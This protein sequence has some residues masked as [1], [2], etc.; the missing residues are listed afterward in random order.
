MIH[1]I[2]QPPND[3]FTSRLFFQLLD[4]LDVPFDAYY[5]WSSTLA[6]GKVEFCNVDNTLE[7]QQGMYD[8]HQDF[9]WEYIRSSIKND[10][11]VIAIKD[12]LTSWNFN[13][14]YHVEPTLVTPLTDI[15]EYHSDKKFI[16]LT[17][18]ENLESYINYKNVIVIPWGGDITNQ[19]IEYKQLPKLLDKN[20][21]SD[22]TFLSLN[23]NQ[24][25]SRIYFL[26]F[27]LGLEI[28]NYGLTSCMFRN[29]LTEMPSREWDFSSYPE[30]E[31][32]YHIGYQ[33]MLTDCFSITDADD[34]YQEGPNDNYNNFLKNLIPYYQNT[35]IEFINETS[36]TESAF[37][38]TEKTANCFY[39]CSFPIW[40]SSPGIVNF[41]R[42]IGLDVFDDIIDHSYD[43]EQHPIQRMY[44]A[45][46]K[47]AHLLINPTLVKQ[48][49]VE[50]TDRFSKNIDFLQHKLY[51]VYYQRAFNKFVN[52]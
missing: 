49:W 36:Y 18:L 41:L 40:I 14:W 2:S 28:E 32:L 44:L 7:E 19:M 46:T 11:V 33:K 43:F 4:T 47:N 22:K 5:A 29:S 39:G 6:Y 26:S 12:H 48:L 45:I 20:L 17:S 16:I 3:E 8:V 38:I 9:Y 50:N 23:R 15:F 27:L 10:L 37:L 25:T 30:L 34:I 35:F 21:N 52:R 24:R 42:S 51:D 1:I 13:P 31:D